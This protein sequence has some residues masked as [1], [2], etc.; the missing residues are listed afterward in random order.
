[1]V[2][3]PERAS[4]I[5][6]GLNHSLALT[7]SGRVYVWGSNEYGQ[8]GVPGDEPRALPVPVGGLPRGLRVTGVSAGSTHSHVITEGGVVFPSAVAGAGSS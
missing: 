7:E 5:S 2:S 6:A 4:A 1:M 8:L 3:L